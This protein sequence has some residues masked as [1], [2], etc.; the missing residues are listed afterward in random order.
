MRG[1]QQ[2]GIFQQPDR[3]LLQTIMGIGSYQSTIMICNIHL[4][5]NLWKYKVQG[6]LI[7]FI[8]QNILGRWR[9][10]E[11]LNKKGRRKRQ[12]KVTGLTFLWMPP[13]LNL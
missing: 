8:C 13:N 7:Y 2:M 12:F 5:L 1:T 4:S 9:G 10:K 3:P 6:E 11:K